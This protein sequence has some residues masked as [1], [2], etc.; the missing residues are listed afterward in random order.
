MYGVCVGWDATGLAGCGGETAGRWTGWKGQRDL[1]KEYERCAK[2]EGNQ[3]T[4]SSE[5]Q[6]GARSVE[7]SDDRRREGNGKAHSRFSW[8]MICLVYTDSSILQ[9]INK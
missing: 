7:G 2:C 4:R 8:L 3:T 1:E 5:D 9:W 6:H